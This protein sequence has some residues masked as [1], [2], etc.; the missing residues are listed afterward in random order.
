MHMMVLSRK[1]RHINK[2]KGGADMT[3]YTRIFIIYYWVEGA[4]LP[5]PFVLSTYVM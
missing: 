2:S 5:P 1:P 3:N 4:R